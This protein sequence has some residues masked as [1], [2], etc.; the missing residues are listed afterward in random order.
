MDARA[1]ILWLRKT[2]D[3]SLLSLSYCYRRIIFCRKCIYWYVL[4][5]KRRTLQ[6]IIHM[7]VF[8]FSPI[9]PTNSVLRVRSL[10]LYPRISHYWKSTKN[11]VTCL[12]WNVFASNSN[13]LI[14]WS[15]QGYFQSIPSYC[16]FI[17]STHAR[18]HCRFCN[19]LEAFDKWA[20]IVHNH[21]IN[22]MGCYSTQ[23]LLSTLWNEDHS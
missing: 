17:S 23:N 8:Y 14:L 21:R 9:I 19:N 12:R 11:C 3:L 4:S 20:C 2:Q 6:K 16:S 1:W 13:L 10:F 5:T 22:S 7:E 15:D 18:K